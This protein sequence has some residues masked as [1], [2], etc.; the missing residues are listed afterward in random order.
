MMSYLECKLF[1]GLSKEDYEE[2]MRCFHP[3]VKIFQSGDDVYSFGGP[4][5]AV[6]IIRKG[7]VSVVRTDVNGVRTIL[8]HAGP[9]EIFG[10][11]FYEGCLWKN[12]ISVLCDQDCE[13]MFID[14]YHIIKRCASACIYHSVL[15][16]N[17]LSLV[18]T[19]AAGLRE[20]IEILS[21]RTIREKLLAYFTL[22]SMR[23]G[24]ERF[25]LPFSFASLAEY[26]C[27]DRSAMMRELKKLKDD[28]LVKT[29]RRHIEF[30][31]KAAAA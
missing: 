12:E 23:A 28:G 29:D 16:Q 24:N 21:C 18:A 15:V 11:I 7:S 14:Y 4:S 17:M 5:K 25:D 22:L 13:I 30:N 1:E 6:G 10:D 8:E 26:L 20:H 9:N 31:K 3:S 2:M 27:V 19:R